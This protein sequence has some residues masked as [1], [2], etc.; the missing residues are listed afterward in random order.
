[1]NGFSVFRF[2]AERRPA[3][4]RAPQVSDGVNRG[5]NRG[6]NPRHEH[7]SA[8][9][10]RDRSLQGSRDFGS[11]REHQRGRFV[12]RSVGCWHLGAGTSVPLAD[13]LSG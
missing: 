2:S 3:P 13:E 6:R 11:R 7:A 10:K 8:P 4:C 9:K 1:L 12:A 5:V